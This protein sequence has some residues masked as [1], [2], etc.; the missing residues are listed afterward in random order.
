MAQTDYIVRAGVGFDIDRQSGQ[1]A[2]KL[3]DV[4]VGG[5]QSA[6]TKKTAEGFAQRQ[7]D[8]D[9]VLSE[10][11]AANKKADDDLVKGTEQVAQR[12]AAAIGKARPKP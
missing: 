12:A 7:R 6:A 3:M 4:F 1:E 9:K 11:A 5:M 8:Y 10:T 2:I